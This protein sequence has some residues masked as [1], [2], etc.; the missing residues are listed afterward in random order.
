MGR[1][2]LL[3]MGS[4][5]ILVSELRGMGG[6]DPVAYRRFGVEPSEAQIIVVKMYFNF[7]GL[8]PIMQGSVMA[9]CPGLSSWD[10]RQ[11]TWKKAPRPLFPLDDLPKWQAS[12]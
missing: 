3:R 6:A 1:A 7:Q 9:D 4:I 8:R 10:L 2:V 12:A 5:D 11:F